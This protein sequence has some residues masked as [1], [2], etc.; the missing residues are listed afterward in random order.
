MRIKVDHEEDEEIAKGTK[1][2]PIV[3]RKSGSKKVKIHMYLDYYIVH[4]YGC[5]I[6]IL[7]HYLFYCLSK[8]DVRYNTLLVP[9]E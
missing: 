9:F 1:T 6:K 5:K 2:F 8:I 4:I 7:Y 3:D